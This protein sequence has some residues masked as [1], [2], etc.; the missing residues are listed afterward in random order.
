M[1]NLRFKISGQQLEKDSGCDFIGIAKGTDEW[2][3]IV[4][5][6]DATW[7]GM[8]KVICMRD[9][10]GN[11]TNK[12]VNGSVTVPNSVTGGDFFSIQIFGKK[13]GKL[14]STNK[15]FIDQV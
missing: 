14:V 7:A 2:L 6:F 10:D 12:I 15:L 9:S 1:R 5:S 13:D 4:M 8:S 11:E 3:N